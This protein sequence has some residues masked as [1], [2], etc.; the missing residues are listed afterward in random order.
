M[1]KSDVPEEAI[2]KA[3]KLLERLLQW[4][5]RFDTRTSVIVGIAVAML[6]VIA[7]VSPA[8]AKW[9][10]WFWVFFLATA[11]LLAGCLV[12]L[13]FGLFPRTNSPNSSLLYFGTIADLK[14]DEFQRRLRA[15]S[16]SEY[17]DDLADQAH[18]NAQILQRKFTCLK[19]ALALILLAAFPWAITVYLAKHIGQ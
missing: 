4:V 10:F 19:I 11:G 9:T 12:A 6:G 17:L 13:Y 18:R 1:A 14:A 8:L 3:E 7:T 16:N 2:E 5:G 15:Q